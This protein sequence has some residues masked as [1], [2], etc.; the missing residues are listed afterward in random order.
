MIG[1]FPVSWSPFSGPRVWAVRERNFLLRMTAWGLAGLSLFYC[2][3]PADP[4]AAR[5]SR[6]LDGIEST[7]E[8]S[9]RVPQLSAQA[10]ISN[11]RSGI[12]ASCVRALHPLEVTHCAIRRRYPVRISSPN[13]PS[14]VTWFVFSDFALDRPGPDLQPA[15]L[16]LGTPMLTYYY[17]S[18]VVFGYCAGYFLMFGSLRGASSKT[19][20]TSLAEPSSE[21]GTLCSHGSRRCV[22]MVCILLCCCF[23]AISPRSP[24][25]TVFAP[26]VRRASIL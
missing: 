25:P 6:F 11:S 21:T 23:G 3:P 4:L 17:L 15:Q 8:I 2:S 26:T 7:P 9:G 20:R 16:A 24:K 12:I 10:K 19:S 18:A 13:L 5:A 14:T 1:F 22:A